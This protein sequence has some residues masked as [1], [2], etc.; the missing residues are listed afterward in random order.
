MSYGPM[1]SASISVIMPAYNESEHIVT[2]LLEV[3]N[4]FNTFGREFEIIVVDDGSSDNTYLNAATTLLQHPERVR[5][6]RY[7]V[8]KGKGNALIAGVC[9][10]RGEYVVF[11]DADM[12]LHPRQLPLF[13]AL[14]ESQHADAV[15]GSKWHPQ[16]QVA[17]P[18]IRRFYSTCY[19]AFVRILFGLPVRDTQAGLKLF[20]MKLLRDVLP[21]LLAKR[22]AFDIEVLAVAHARGYKIVDAPVTL[23]F[24]RPMGRLRLHHAWSTLVDTLAIFYRLK[25]LHY[26]D[27]LTMLEVTNG[28]EN[29]TVKELSAADE[30]MPAEAGSAMRVS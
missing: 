7:E 14:M 5:I 22:F 21:R 20:T 16:S 1:S 23:R 17:Y 25:V 10:A 26:Y 18:K 6:V 19:Y 15:I 12:D 13:L 11:L 9:K 27:Q 2:N 24:Q 28:I 8:N 3:V 4:V 29:G 30:P